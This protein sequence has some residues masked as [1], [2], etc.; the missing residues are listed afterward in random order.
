[1]W[2]FFLEV[3]GLER[4]RQR[5]KDRERE[6]ERGVEGKKVRGGA[7]QEVTL[8]HVLENQVFVDRD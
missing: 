6:R 7:K 8:R 1:M 5:E 4:E 2:D 3:E